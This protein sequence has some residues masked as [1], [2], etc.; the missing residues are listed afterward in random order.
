MVKFS[1]MH[2]V[3][4]NQFIM[5]GELETLRFVR[6]SGNRA[7]SSMVLSQIYNDSNDELILP[8]SNLVEFHMGIVKSSKVGGILMFASN[9]GPAGSGVLNINFLNAEK[10]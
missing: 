6:V 10:L 5:D 4:I 2:E 9:K 8:I 1:K 7:N 3:G